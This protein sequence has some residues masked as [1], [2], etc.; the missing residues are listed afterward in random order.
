MIE[1]RLNVLWPK[2]FGVLLV[3]K[4]DIPFSPMD[5]GF[6]RPIG[7]PRITNVLTQKVNKT[8]GVFRNTTSDIVH[9]ITSLVLF[10]YSVLAI[11]VSVKHQIQLRCAF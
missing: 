7:Q 10:V 8:S 9:F 11:V 2:R 1:K 4:L 3:V 5:I 6:F